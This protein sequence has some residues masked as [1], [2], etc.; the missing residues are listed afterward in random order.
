MGPFGGFVSFIVV[1]RR[2]TYQNVVV[3]FVGHRRKKVVLDVV[4]ETKAEFQVGIN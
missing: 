3:R 1:A 4:Q 2:T